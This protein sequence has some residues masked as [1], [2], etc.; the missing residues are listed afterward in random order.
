MNS[1]YRLR[2]RKAGRRYELQLNYYNYIMHACMLGLEELE[3]AYES[4][5]CSNIFE[6]AKSCLKNNSFPHG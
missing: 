4:F 3:Y 5:T 2:I 6:Y 1:V